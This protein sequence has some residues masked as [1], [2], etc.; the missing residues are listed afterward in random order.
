MRAEQRRRQRLRRRR[1]RWWRRRP[2][3]FE[4]GVT[5]PKVTLI[6]YQPFNY[7]VIKY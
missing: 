7:R 2:G 3:G 6:S 5:G 4:T 1:R